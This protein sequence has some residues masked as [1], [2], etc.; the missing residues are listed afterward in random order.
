MAEPHDDMTELVNWLVKQQDH[1]QRLLDAADT[2]D[3]RAT[4]DELM[5]M[6]KRFFSLSQGFLELGK[7]ASKAAEALIRQTED[8]GGAE[9]P[10]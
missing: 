3:P 1:L 9:S 10:S 4:F 6:S 7:K 8:D 2:A 5:A